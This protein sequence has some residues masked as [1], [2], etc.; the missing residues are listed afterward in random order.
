MNLIVY[1]RQ[2]TLTHELEYWRIIGPWLFIN[3]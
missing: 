1:C 2:T 3:S